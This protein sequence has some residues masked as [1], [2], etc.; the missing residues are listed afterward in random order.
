MHSR[1]ACRAS[2]L[3]RRPPCPWNFSLLSSPEAFWEQFFSPSLITD[4]TVVLGLWLIAEFRSRK[5]NS[6]LS[7]VKSLCFWGPGSSPWTRPTS[8]WNFS[9]SC[10][11][12]SWS[13]ISPTP[14]AAPWVNFLRL[15]VDPFILY[16]GLVM[17]S[18]GNVLISAQ[19]NGCVQWLHYCKVGSSEPSDGTMNDVIYLVDG[20][21]KRKRKEKKDIPLTRE[22]N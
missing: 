7:L 13:V 2:W 4:P 3:A 15:G 10:A 19:S 1:R 11:P 20:F 12:E 18:K 8:F 5:K 6:K 14:R 22:E 16:R 21:T 9:L 17:Y